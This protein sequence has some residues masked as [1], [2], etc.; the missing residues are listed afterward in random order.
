MVQ[1]VDYLAIAPPLILA[2][3]G[4]AALF[5]RYAAFVG[6]VLAGAFEVVLLTGDPRRTFCVDSSCSFV[7]D[8]FTLLF[9]TV[10]LIAGLVV[11][12]MAQVEVRDTRLP[13]GEFHFLILAAM[14]GALTLA[15]GR[16]LVTLLVS[17]EVVSLPLFA[18]VALRRYDGRSS[19]AGVKMFLVSVVSTAVMLFGI[20]LV[21]G[22][23]GSLFLDRIGAVLATPSPLESVAAV[24]IVLVLVGFGFKVSA[25][26]FHFWAPDTYQGSPVAVAAFLSVISK[27]AGFAG[28]ALVLTIAFGPFAA[29]WGPLVAVLAAVSM[30]VGNLVAL[31]QKTAMR[32]LA[33]S[34]IAQAGYMLAPLGA[35]GGGAPLNELVAATIGYVAIYAVMNIGVFAVISVVGWI[36]EH[37]G[38]ALDDYRGLARTHPLTAVALAFF[39]A[40]LA[41][42]PPG[43]A[44]LFAKIVVFQGTILGGYGWLAVIMAVN[45]VIGLFYYLAWA[46]R[47]FAPLPQ[48]ATFGRITRPVGA[49]IGVAAVGTVLVS[50]APQ[51]VLGISLGG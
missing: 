16:D 5:L 26:P 23:T 15:A 13:S 29:V 45:T 28:L 46:T 24:G 25:V 3:C 4:L 14:S 47:L 34:S 30:T 18:L 51:L 33:W 7:V 20:S 36:G 38:G 35:A 32:L 50:F 43:L 27:A 31:R 22:A 41:G 39:L 42:L 1:S 48:G 19:E 2:L 44:G 49:A 17:L 9:Q 8:D 21:Y 37:G 6:L 10:M 11:V 40:C 12:L